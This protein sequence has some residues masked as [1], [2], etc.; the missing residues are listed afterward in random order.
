VRAGNPPDL[1]ADLLYSQATALAATPHASE[2]LPL[3]REARR[4]FEQ[5]LATAQSPIFAGKLAHVVSQTSRVHASLNDYPAAVA[6]ARDAIDRWRA[7]SGRDSPDEAYGWQS[8]GTILALEGKRGEALAAFREAVRIR[9]ARLGEAPQT[10]VSLVSVANTLRL[11]GRWAESVAAY[12]RALQIDRAQLPADDPRLAA[13]LF[14]RASP[15]KRLGRLD[16]A[17]ASFDEAIAIYERAGI[18]EGNV[19]FAYHDRADLELERNQL[20]A[21]RADYARSIALAE[22][23]AGA[24]SAMMI[25]PLIGLAGCL[26]MLDR[27]AEAIAPL[28][29]VLTLPAS[30]DDAMMITIARGYLGRARLETRRDVAG[31]LAMVRAARAALAS[32]RDA[33]EDVRDIDSWLATPK[34]R[35]ILRRAK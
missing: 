14:G 30:P 33:A 31:G 11:E 10:A 29:R 6:A 17:A 35:A 7:L 1:E 32:D 21:A 5:A 24:R 26:L 4:L 28:E 16:E 23:V 19:A 2:A 13:V 8:L 18:K 27:P 25:Y 3:L 15:I 34:V 22:Q 12:D 9:E 20:E